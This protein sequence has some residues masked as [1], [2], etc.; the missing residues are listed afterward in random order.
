MTA[1]QYVAAALMKVWF[2][3]SH[4]DQEWLASEDGQAWTEISYL[5]AQVAVDA[6]RE[7][8]QKYG[9]DLK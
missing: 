9:D 8:L 4:T 6:Y 2:K 5:D 1:E 3:N 7:W